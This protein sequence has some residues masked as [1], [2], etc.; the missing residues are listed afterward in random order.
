MRRTQLVVLFKHL[1]LQ[2]PPF[3]QEWKTL[4]LFR[5]IL[6]TLTGKTHNAVDCPEVVRVGDFFVAVDFLL[7][8]SPVWKQ[9]V[10]VGPHGHCG[11]DVEQLEDRRLGLE[12]VVLS[13]V[14]RIKSEQ[15]VVV[16]GGLRLFVVDDGELLVGW[17]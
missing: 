14:K 16:S 13:L 3:G 8:E 12:H 10:V 11:W 9:L 7:V 2:F 15:S 1:E 6:G 17:E 4:D 5:N